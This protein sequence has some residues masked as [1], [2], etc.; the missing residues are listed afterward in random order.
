MAA[1]GLKI[2]SDLHL[3]SISISRMNSIAEWFERL[4]VNA[5]VASVMGSIPAP[6]DTMES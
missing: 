6:S 5:E 2:R 1:F 4:A 3:Q